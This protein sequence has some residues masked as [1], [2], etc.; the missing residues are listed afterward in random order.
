MVME[1]CFLSLSIASDAI[2]RPVKS[3]G[4]N[5]MVKRRRQSRKKVSLIKKT[6]FYGK[7]GVQGSKRHF[8][9]RKMFG[10]GHGGIEINHVLLRSQELEIKS[11]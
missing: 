3:A 10:P 4:E 8:F 6:L 7:W 9:M 11:F 5:K 2:S 1:E